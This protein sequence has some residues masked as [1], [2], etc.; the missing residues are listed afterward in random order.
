MLSD[1]GVLPDDCIIAS[2]DVASL[3]SNIPV[4]ESIDVVM[5]FLKLHWK[6]VDMFDLSLSDVR[7]LLSVVQLLPI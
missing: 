7:V 2:L 6:E 4:V 1:V 5:E 3:Y